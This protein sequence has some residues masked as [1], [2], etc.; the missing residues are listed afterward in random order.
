MNR[1]SAF[2]YFYKAEFLRTFKSLEYVL[3]LFLP[4]PVTLLS[5]SSWASKTHDQYL[6]ISNNDLHKNV[7]QHIIRSGLMLNIFVIPLLF[8]LLIFH[9]INTDYK[10]NMWRYSMTIPFATSL[11]LPAKQLV[12]YIW[13][14]AQIGLLFVVFVSLPFILPIINPLIPELTSHKFPTS[15]L[16]LLLTKYSINILA[17]LAFQ[18]TFSFIFPNRPTIMIL[19]PIVSFISTFVFEILAKPTPSVNST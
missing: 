9:H 7:W 17:V 5:V 8:I 3:F 4:I 10:R 1:L 6:S 2:F 13:F 18:T 16:F 14:L 19:L 12:L 11:L 15:I